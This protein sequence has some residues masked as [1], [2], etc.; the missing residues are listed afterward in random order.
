MIER[1]VEQFGT[2]DILVNNAHDTRPEVIA[3]PFEQLSV[4]QM[5]PS[6]T[7]AQSL[8]WWPC[9]RV[10]PTSDARADV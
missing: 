1:V 6:S 5:R 8:R 4:D 2:V 3:A 7:A 10:F 9:R